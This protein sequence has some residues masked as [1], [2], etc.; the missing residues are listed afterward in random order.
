MGCAAALKSTA[1]VEPDTPKSQLRGQAS[2]QPSLR[3]A[4]GA[5]QIV[6]KP[7]SYAFG[8]SALTFSWSNLFAK[9]TMRCF[10]ATTVLIL[11]GGRRSLPCPRS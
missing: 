7:D 5:R 8:R 9:L 3:F 10:G 11:A 2:L 4:A 1:S 6:G